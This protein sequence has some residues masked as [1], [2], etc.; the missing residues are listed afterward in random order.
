MLKLAIRLIEVGGEVRDL[1][2]TLPKALVEGFLYQRILDRVVDPSLKP[3][4]AVA[5][6][7]RRLTAAMIP[8]VLGEFVPEG[9]DPQDLFGR[10]A[11]E[12]ALV[13]RGDAGGQGAEAPQVASVA[14]ASVLR[15]RADVRSATLRLLELD[16]AAR[17]RARPR[18]A[19]WYARQDL[20]DTANAAELVYHR[21]RLGDVKGAEQAWRDGCAPL[22][23]DAEDDLPETAHV[24]RQ[25]LRKRVVGT[26]TPSE[27]LE[28][29][30]KG[31]AERICAVLARGLL[32]AV[33]E[34]LSERAERSAAS[35]VVLYDAWM[36][37]SSG[38]LAGAR[39][40][41][42]AAGEAGEAVGRD[43]AVLGALLAARA[44]DRPG[45]DRLLVRIEDEWQ[46]RDR[47]QG[48]LEALAVLAARIHLTVDLDAELELSRTLNTEPDV[49]SVL[50]ELKKFVTPMDLV[51]P[52]LSR[53]VRNEAG[54]ESLRKP[55]PIPEERSQLARFADELSNERR[56]TLVEPRSVRLLDGLGTLPSEPPG[57]WKATDLLDAGQTTLGEGR[58]PREFT[59]GLDLAIMGWRR[60]C[61]ATTNLFLARACEQA[62]RTE[63]GSLLDQSIVGTLA[64]FRSDEPGATRLVY[65]SLTLD[66]VLTEA[67]SRTRTWVPPPSTADR[68]TLTAEL[69]PARTGDQSDE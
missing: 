40:V 34:I 39:A 13:R 26:M 54:L 46:W 51:L 49:T 58:F 25:W 27:A 28:S 3:V 30:E 23:L 50:A 64:I 15:L 56:R 62:L 43:R 20:D 60:W 24:A 47:K 44:D 55:I 65:Q 19:D 57:P 36:R 29:W 14:G 6:V 11:H 1:P 7:L 53:Q 35:P 45:A 21:L 63:V 42:D 33:P 2:E 41:L 59:L 5:L 18:A 4:G 48:P 31:A 52:R 32:C 17:A 12:L 16:D 9:S 37:W 38:D 67:M 8:E 68:L 61:L 10:L 69:L 22:L 66:A